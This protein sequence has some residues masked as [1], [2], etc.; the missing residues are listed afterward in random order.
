MK[1]THSIESILGSRSRVRVLRVLHGVHAPLNSTQVAARTQLTKVAVG[2]ALAELAAMGLVTST[3]VGRSIVHTLVRDNVFVER[4]V[5]PVFAAEEAIPEILEEELRDAFALDAESIVLFGSYARG[6]QQEESDV[7]AV[8]VSS[9]D[10][11]DALERRV[12]EYVSRFR[13]RFGATLSPLVYDRQEAA[14]LS[15]RAPALF[16]SIVQDAIVLMGVGPLEWA[17]R[18]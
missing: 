12:D 15:T 17:K 8:L 5:S 7:D 4:M 11:K 10:A 14:E 2:N 9:G 18:G 16:D 1:P 13:T 6:E 3:P